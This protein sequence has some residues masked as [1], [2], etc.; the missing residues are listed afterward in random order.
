MSLHAETTLAGEQLQLLPERA[1][2]WPRLRTLIVADL[3]WGKEETFRAAA[4]PVPGGTL[5]ADLARLGSALCRTG[6]E[7]LLVLGDLW[8]DRAG[9][10]ESLL[11][12]LLNWRNSFANLAIELVPG[13]HDRGFGPFQSDLRL[14]V[15]DHTLVE[16]PF[17]FRHFP[18]PSTDGYVLAGHIHP[19]VVLRG[20]GRQKLRLPCFWLGA[21]V[22]VLPSF[23][24]FTGHGDVLPK[25]GDRVFV[26]A[27]EEVIAVA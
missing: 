9:R 6:S 15:R 10:A 24:Q 14:S 5:Q 17:V 22:G 16:A 21:A 23:G 8:H 13:N 19:A 12:T 1:I 7:R 3:H 25:R 2:Y 18:D 20:E 11:E 4:I 26:I 27:G